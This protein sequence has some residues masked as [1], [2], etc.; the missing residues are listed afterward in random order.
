MAIA[1]ALVLLVSYD[2]ENDRDRRAVA[3][4]L[5]GYGERV[6]YSVFECALDRWEAERLVEGLAE[7]SRRAN[8]TFSVRCYSLD[9]RAVARVRTIG[10]GGVVQDVPYYIA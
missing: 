4:Y 8:G 7:R 6:Q 3:R 1:P 5:Q 9:G 10:S 2:I